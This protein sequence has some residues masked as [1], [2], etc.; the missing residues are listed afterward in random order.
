MA[1]PRRTRNIVQDILSQVGLL[2]RLERKMR[3]II[4]SYAVAMGLFVL[5]VPIAVQELVST[6]SFA[7]EPRRIIF[8]SHDPSFISHVD[9][10]IDLE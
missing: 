5:C 7:V 8:G 1:P 4:A 9:R 10:Q 3:G 2:V 6:L